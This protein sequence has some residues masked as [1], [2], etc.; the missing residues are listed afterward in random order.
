MED[1][2]IEVLM[3]GPMMLL[4][5]FSVDRTHHNFCLSTILDDLTSGIFQV[6]STSQAVT[7]VQ[8][9]RRLLQS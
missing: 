1:E 8:Y 4:I 3:E 9:K 6:S 5:S 2:M 7:R